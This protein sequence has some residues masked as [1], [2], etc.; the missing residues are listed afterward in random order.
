M[1]DEIEQ[2]LFEAKD[3]MLDYSE[4]DEEILD[5]FIEFAMENVDN[6]GF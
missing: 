2:A 4:V 6:A 5:R 1:R 3:K